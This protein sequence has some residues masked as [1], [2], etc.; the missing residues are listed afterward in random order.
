MRVELVMEDP[1]QV[2]AVVA[3]GNQNMANVKSALPGRIL[4]RCLHPRLQPFLR[5][6]IPKPSRTSDSPTRCSQ[7][8]VTSGTSRPPKFR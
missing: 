7:P 4:R 8:S 2:V 1:A 5:V 6:R 3:P